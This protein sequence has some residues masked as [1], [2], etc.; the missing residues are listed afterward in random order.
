MVRI[1]L[2]MCETDLWSGWAMSRSQDI[3]SF[4]RGSEG[5][6]VIATDTNRFPV[7]I[8]A[9]LFLSGQSFLDDGTHQFH[10]QLH[11]FWDSRE[12]LDGHPSSISQAYRIQPWVI[13]TA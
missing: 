4:Y 6:A 13:H 9:F 8:P 11:L 5:K 2:V 10:P 12:Q 7:P 3:T 1:R